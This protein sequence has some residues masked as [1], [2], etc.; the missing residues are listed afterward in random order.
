MANLHLL[1]TTVQNLDSHAISSVLDTNDA[2]LLLDDGNYL[3]HNLQIVKSLSSYKVYTVTEQIEALAL[4]CPE[5]FSC[6]D[7]SQAL[8]LMTTYQRTITWQ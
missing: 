1:R 2:I 4:N 7:Y 5:E 8:D 3:C 6:I